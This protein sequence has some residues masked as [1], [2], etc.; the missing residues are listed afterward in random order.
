[1]RLAH[2]L[3]L[4][5]I[6]AVLVTVAAMGGAMIWNLH[7][8]FADY[9]QARD[10]ERLEHFAQLVAERIAAAG[11]LSALVGQPEPMRSLLDA[12]AERDGVNR[13]PAPGLMPPGL[14]GGPP[15]PGPWSERGAF[16]PHRPPPG[17]EGAG[18]PFGR[19]VAVINPQ[20]Q[21]VLGL[22]QPADA[23]TRSLP[24]SL[25]GQT[26][27][28]VRM[29]LVDDAPAG[30]DARFLQRQ[31]TALAAVSATLLLLV[32]ALAWVLARRWVRPLLAVQA[33]TH[34]IALGHLDVRLPESAGSDE[35][36]ELVRNVNRMA[37]AL[38]QLQGARR[39]WLAEISHELRTPLTVLRGELDALADGIRPL[40]PAA[41]QSL[42]DEVQALGKI[43]DDLREL[44]VSDLGSLSFEHRPVAMQAVLERVQ[45]RFAQRASQAGLV[46]TLEPAAAAG[47]QV[48]G[49]AGRLE[50]LLSNLLEN[51]LRYTDAPGR[52]DIDIT[53]T[54]PTLTLQVQDSAPGVA[55][56]HLPHL[57]EPL[58]RV[59]AARSRSNGGSGLGLAICDAIARAHGG[60]MQASPSALGG[61]CIRLTLPLLPDSATAPPP[62]EPPPHD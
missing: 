55:A 19:R 50:Q 42:Q 22:R 11:S 52:V 24:V 61:L 32:V 5:L 60:Q 21:Q 49:D 23:P 27:A 62:A 46:L 40:N 12:L 17:T 39:R 2:T 6:A 43:V 20:G 38:Q 4:M 26:V 58:Y 14:P 15:P 45:Q 8:G 13:P 16:A 18:P 53:R 9:L 29:V 25:D 30:V 1:M 54:G 48:S 41:V 34:R 31:Y 36:A 37:S 3:S 10:N 57:F 33:A 35:V 7:S 44:A 28:T 47:M 56:S 51:S 59:D